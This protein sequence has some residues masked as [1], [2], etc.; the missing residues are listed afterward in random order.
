MNREL[1]DNQVGLLFAACSE[2]DS[3]FGDK[4]AFYKILA[5]SLAGKNGAFRKTDRL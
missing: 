2:V 5:D 4:P 1:S 3:R